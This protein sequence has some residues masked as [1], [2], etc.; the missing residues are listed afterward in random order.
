MIFMSLPAKKAIDRWQSNGKSNDNGQ[1]RVVDR[2]W[3]VK[4]LN[5]FFFLFLDDGKGTHTH[6]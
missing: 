5:S 2:V 3:E 1:C 6:T 4:R